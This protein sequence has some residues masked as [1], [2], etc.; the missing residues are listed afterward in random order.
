MMIENASFQ[1]DSFGENDFYIFSI[2]YETRSRLLYEKLHARLNQCNSLTIIIDNSYLEANLRKQIEQ[3][4][5][6]F[7]IEYDQQEKMVSRI[8]SFVEGA[9]L[10][11]KKVTIHIDYSAMPRA[12]YCNLAVKLMHILRADDRVYFW[13]AEGQYRECI[14]CYPTAGTE[15]YSFFSGKASICNERPRI[16]I[17]ALGFD[18]I[19]ANA[20]ISTL[21]PDYVIACFAFY[22]DDVEVKNY[23]KDCNKQI[24]TK[25]A[26]TIELHINDFYGM[27]SKIVD[28]SNELLVNGDVILIPDGPKPLILAMSLAPLIIDKP[29]V[30]CLHVA[31]NMLCFSKI[32]IK[33]TGKFFGFSLTA[34]DNVNN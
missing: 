17:I 4:T 32:D 28:I 8:V 27:L 10:T 31:R 11:E 9:K 13:Y 12:W 22:P 19:R 14:S 2:N 30:S 18:P 1:D 25:S 34:M 29:G 6:I 15:Q 5:E 20:I 23:I 21:D 24:I 26:M 3:T 7:S 16:H 33:P